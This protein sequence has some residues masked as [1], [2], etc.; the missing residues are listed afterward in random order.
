M[1]QLRT[2]FFI[3]SIFLCLSWT[4]QAQDEENS[5]ET[6]TT[7]LRYGLR[8][9]ADI[10]KLVR[11]TLED[12]YSGFEINADYR[13]T[14]D[15]YI[16]AEIGSEEKTTSND[17]LSITADGSYIKIGADYNMYDNWLGTENMIFA[18]FRLGTSTFSQTRNSYTVF[19][20]NQYWQPQFTNTES[21]TTSGLTAVWIEV[22]FG[23]KAEV[24]NNLYVGVNVQLKGMITQDQPVNYENLHVP[25][26]NKTF[27]SG[28]I[29]VGYAYN[30]S[31]FIPII[32]KAP[33]AKK[34]K[35]ETPK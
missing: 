12:D 6:D 34:E 11:T 5:I 17:F 14:R 2:T 1:K 3:T 9:G 16:A 24:L 10:S 33:K 4:T 28:F 32:K 21:F 13:L 27:D 18:G 20:T 35:V 31:Y 8:I 15:W 7:Q 29:G 22:M 30:I 23:I 19:T 26:F 25:G